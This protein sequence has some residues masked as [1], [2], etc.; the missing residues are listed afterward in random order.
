[1]AKKTIMIKIFPV[2]LLLVL[3]KSPAFAQYYYKDIISVQ[4]LKADMDTFKAKKINTILVHSFEADDQPSKGFFCQKQIS[5]TFKRMDTY[6]KTTENGKSLL[7]SFF[8][9]KGFLIQS[10]DSS[11][12]SIS[13]A[14]YQYNKDGTLASISTTSSSKD[15]DFV[16]SL[17]EV[18]QYSYDDK[19]KL[20]KM[21]LIKNSKD[22]TE[23]DFTIDNKGNVSDES[24]VS[25]D[26]LHYYYYYD[27]QNR[28][29]DIAHYNVVKQKTLPDFIF[30]YDD[31]GQPSQM[32]IT[33]QGATSNYN[34]WTYL[35]DD[36]LRIKEKCYS[37]EK[38]LLGYFEYEYINK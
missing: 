35:Y 33:Q 29:T 2:L 17:S 6:T 30:E 22:T 23:I 32:I 11:D 20:Q 28:L 13:T 4:Q 5:K 25:A 10:K 18:H 15:D 26:G 8:D 36:N 12:F 14:N 21:L 34:I 3:I 31:Y 27:A 24:E 19:G 37:K 16:T 1:M 9:D 38:E 7:S